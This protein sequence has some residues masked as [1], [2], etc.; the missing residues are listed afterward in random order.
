MQKQQTKEVQNHFIDFGN[1]LCSIFDQLIDNVGTMDL[2]GIEIKLYRN[3]KQIKVL[4]LRDTY[5]NVQGA[6]IRM[7]HF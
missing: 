5:F 6:P 3:R 7:V 1:I 4:T 2:C